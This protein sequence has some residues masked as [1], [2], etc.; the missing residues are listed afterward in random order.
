[1]SAR[2]AA[3]SKSAR[4]ASERWTAAAPVQSVPQSALEKQQ[5]LDRGMLHG[6]MLISVAPTEEWKRA[7]AVLVEHPRMPH[8]LEMID[9]PLMID[10]GTKLCQ[11]HV[12]QRRVVITTQACSLRRAVNHVPLAGTWSAERATCMRRRPSEGGMIQ[13][14]TVRAQKRAIGRHLREA[15]M[16][17]ERTRHQ[18][19]HQVVAMQGARPLVTMVLVDWI[20]TSSTSKA[21]QEDVTFER[22]QQAERQ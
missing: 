6:A 9:T 20:L 5:R 15:S 16:V 11:A 22:R 1:M 2:S 12:W 21:L 19:R 7:G 3:E 17:E 18:P 14:M 8:E 4:R 13:Q 10:G